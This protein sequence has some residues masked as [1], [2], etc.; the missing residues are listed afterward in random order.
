MYWMGSYAWAAAATVCKRIPQSKIKDNFFLSNYFSSLSP[1]KKPGKVAIIIVLIMELAQQVPMWEE[2]CLNTE[3]MAVVLAAEDGA[4]IHSKY[5]KAMEEVLYQP[6][7]LWAVE[8]CQKIGI[9]QVVVLAQPGQD[10]IEQV[11]AAAGVKTLTSLEQTAQAIGQTK[12]VLVLPGDVFIMESALLE[13]AFAFYKEQSAL[14]AAISLMG[15]NT[16]AA[17]FAGKE[18]AARLKRAENAVEAFAAAEAP[19]FAA[20]LEELCLFETRGDLLE[21]NRRANRREIERLWEN[22]VNIYSTDGIV[23]S[24]KAQVG[25]DTTIHPGTQLKGA[26]IIGEDCQIGPNT[27][28][29]NSTIGDGSTIHSSFIEASAVGNGVR[30]G[31]NSHLRPNSTLGDKVKIGNFVEVKNSLL[32]EGSSV[33]HL[34]YVGDT[35]MGAHVNMG[36]GC[37]CVNYNGYTKARTVIEDNAFIGCNTNL[38]APVTV[39]TGAFTAAGSTI[40][41]EVPAGALGI[42]RARQVNIAGWIAKHREKAMAGKSQK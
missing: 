39:K 14:A 3:K 25:Q 7:V 2:Y 13:K 42:A 11:V 33:A 23:I 36:G 15:K 17:W 18:L 21:I 12:D 26:V 9:D 37:I 29:E 19:C 31:P 30:I 22:G 38:V 34:T 5:P 16:G 35:D 40:T 28:V 20:T 4:C 1:L 32:G 24:P 27:V 10:K 41:E 8:F 6:M